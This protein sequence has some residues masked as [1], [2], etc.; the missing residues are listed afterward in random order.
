MKRS[1][2]LDGEVPVITPTATED[3]QREKATRASSMRKSSTFGD[4]LQNKSDD[5]KAEK[6]TETVTGRT[7]S[8][9]K[10]AHEKLKCTTSVESET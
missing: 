4:E 5:E 7:P 10:T 6:T 9:R 2:S 8:L 3:K 1:T